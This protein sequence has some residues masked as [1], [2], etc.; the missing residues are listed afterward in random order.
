MNALKSLP[1]IAILLIS[2]ALHAAEVFVSHYEPLRSL[3]VRKTGPAGANP[4][5]QALAVASTALSFEALG[6]SF[7]LELEPN[8]RVLAGISP[9]ALA[10]GVVAYRGR[11][12]NKPESWAR[13]VMFAGMPRGLVWDGE[14]MF[15]IEAPGDSAV[16]TK[17]PIVYRL[18]DLYIPPGTMSCGSTS[19]PRNAAQ[20][21][22]K[23]QRE[24]GD[25][26]AQA[27][28][29][30]SEITIGVIGDAQFTSSQGG[31]A[32]AA[33]AITARF[34]NIDGYFSEQV[35]V[36]IGVRRIDTFDGASDPFDDTLDP[37]SL[38]DQV[39]EYRLQTPEQN[40]LG[41]THLYTGR[42]FTTTTVGIAWNGALCQDY[43]GAGLSEGGRAGLLTDS[44][45]AAHEIGHNFGA[46]HDGDPNGSCPNTPETFIMAASVNGNDQFSACSIS[47][48]QAVAAGASCVAPL[49]AV[50]VGISQ[51]GQV[52]SVLL[53]AATDIN[54]EVSSNGTVSVSGVVA[55]FSLPA[56]LA[57]DAVTSSIGTC[58]SG[59]GTV[60]CTLGDL[61]GL[62]NHTI[63]ISTTP[64]NVG[65]GMVNAVVTTTDTDERTTNNQDALQVTVSPAVDL[66]VSALAT[67]PVLVDESATVTATLE[68]L[69][70]MAASN[71]SLSITLAAGLQVDSATWPVGTCTVSAQQVDCQASNFDAL[72]SSTLSISAT[73]LTTGAQ[74]VS[75]SLTSTDI[76]A[77]P[78]NNSAS[79][80]VT[81]VNPD[82]DD[83]DDG[84]GGTTNPLF[85]LTMIVAGLLGR[86]YRRSL[87]R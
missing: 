15:A 11:L 34:N 3:D 17:S 37:R 36:Q 27:P 47:E 82:D 50:D 87:M 60:S 76:D 57:L 2:P 38:L 43:F 68:N 72:S 28:G 48:M 26:I 86:N 81:V 66:V 44:L 67:P 42:E 39:S 1:V 22:T 79:G 12:A 54:Y 9:E 32:A 19:M 16:E 61:P 59:A 25:V 69:S 73:A 83:D 10:S 30:V 7:D 33:A 74:N 84:G 6:K 85:I 20:A 64:I 5:H 75:A 71:V 45:V 23:I 52:S 29:A 53:S 31:D 46:D 21:Y 65:A 4:G 77:D 58:S 13:I 8:E 78:S 24:L 40:S 41:L 49:P 55:D 14:T 80:T 18:D 63:T 51:D 56:T 62:S 35:G 70:T